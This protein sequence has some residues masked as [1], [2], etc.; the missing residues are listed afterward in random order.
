[1]SGTRT[2]FDS[3]MTTD[4]EQ[5][6][7]ARFRTLLLIGPPGAGKGTLGGILGQVPRFF[8]VSMGALLRSVPPDTETGRQILEEQ[9]SGNLV[10]SE[11]V[12]SVWAEYMHQHI[13]EDFEPDR[14]TLVLDGL[15]RNVE[16]AEMLEPHASIERVI[17]LVC[18]HKEILMRRIRNRWASQERRDDADEAVIQRRFDIYREQTEPVFEYYA[19]TPLSTIDATLT[20][21]RVLCQVAEALV[22]HRPIVQ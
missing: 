12:V 2:T 6:A 8:F 20:P 1:M 13:G 7:D 15:P 16:Q 4:H 18:S 19:Q 22:T 10:P 21:L 3:S 11:S 9:K 14:D 17:H 5:N